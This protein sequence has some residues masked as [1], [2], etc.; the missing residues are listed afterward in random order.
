MNL[1]GGFEWIDLQESRWVDWFEWEFFKWFYLKAI[2]WLHILQ[3]VYLH[4]LIE[5][6]NVCVFAW[7]ALVGFIWISIYLSGFNWWFMNAC[8]WCVDELIWEIGLQACM[9]RHSF[10]GIRLM[11]LIWVIFYME[12][13]WINLFGRICLAGFV[14]WIYLH[15]LDCRIY[16]GGFV[17]AGLF[18]WIDL[19]GLSLNGFVWSNSLDDFSWGDVFGWIG[20]HAFM[21]MRSFE[22]MYLHAFMWMQLFGQCIWKGLTCRGPLEK[23]VERVV[24]R[25][26]FACIDLNGFVWRGVFDWCDLTVLFGCMSLNGCFGWVCLGEF[27][28]VGLFGKGVVWM[29][30]GK[31]YLNAS[32]WMDPFESIY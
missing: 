22:G 12:F 3:L 20:L 14:A 18:D 5:G 21:W 26:W 4:E 28:W 31:G 24:W 8:I 15:K 1:Y 9:R 30:W 16:W 23:L 7:I 29:I 19:A 27:I 10:A 2:I 6:I 32:I 11:E 17:W 13:I 25:H